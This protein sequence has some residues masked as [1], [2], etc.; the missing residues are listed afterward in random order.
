MRCHAVI[1]L[2]DKKVGDIKIDD[3][4]KELI[5]QP[6]YAIYNEDR[7]YKYTMD[8]VTFFSNGK[9]Y[10]CRRN[11]V[12]LDKNLK[13][14]A[15]DIELLERKKFDKAIIDDERIIITGISTSY[16][17]YKNPAFD[18]AKTIKASLK[19]LR[20]ICKENN[21]K[22]RLKNSGKLDTY[23]KRYEA[24]VILYGERYQEIKILVDKWLKIHLIGNH[25]V[26]PCELED[27][28]GKLHHK[29][30]QMIYTSTEMSKIIALTYSIKKNIDCVLNDEGF[31][32]IAFN[33]RL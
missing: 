10:K 13:N 18:S 21:I 9:Y 19:K 17:N 7:F 22:C 1:D 5:K 33:L 20:V 8:N 15:F 16:H 11:G 12:E 29:M 31:T 30:N 2:R 27:E 28:I 3:I 6:N 26:K 25:H 14:L 24:D 4:V 23:L 32:Y